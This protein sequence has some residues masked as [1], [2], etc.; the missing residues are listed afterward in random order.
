MKSSNE[1][2]TNSTTGDLTTKLPSVVVAEH[3][4]KVA[5]MRTN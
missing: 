2:T 1:L 3:D 4:D 5:H